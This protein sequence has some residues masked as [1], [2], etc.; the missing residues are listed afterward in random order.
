VERLI[1][2]RHAH[3]VSN[4]SD[5]TS[6]T[7]VGEGLTDLG[8]A[9]GAALSELLARET[10]S[11]GVCSR[12]LRTRE[13]LESGLAGTSTPRLT[14]AELDEI[15]F[16]SFEGGPVGEYRRW[17]FAA[18][19]DAVCP[20]GGESRSG[21]AARMAGALGLLLGRPEETVVAVSHALT[22]RYALDAANGLAP[23]ARI[24]PVAHATPFALSADEVERARSLLGRWA[25][26]P[27]FR[28]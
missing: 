1:L 8:R 12:L 13:T 14:M 25:L 18:S 21:V 27:R 11:L 7:P 5:V 19:A 4:E 24:A 9:Q 2:V 6:C 22:V 15:H 28:E 23:A 10:V 3:A 20:G 17:A 16:G 26:A